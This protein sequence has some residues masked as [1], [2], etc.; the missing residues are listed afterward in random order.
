VA[1]LVARIEAERLAVRIGGP[2][3]G[4]AALVWLNVGSPFEHAFRGIL[5]VTR[6]LPPPG[7]DGLAPQYLDEIERLVTATGGRTLGLFSS[8]RGGPAGG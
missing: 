5:Y 4:C 3:V 1:E 7:R 6:H 8:M 2:G